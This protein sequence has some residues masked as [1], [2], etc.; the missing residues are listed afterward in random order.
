[1]YVCSVYGEVCMYAGRQVTSEVIGGAY[2]RIR[3]ENNVC[4]IMYVC[5]IWCHF[6]VLLC[7][8]LKEGGRGKYG[9]RTTMTALPTCMMCM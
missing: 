5:I 3:W 1:M 6:Y 9:C 7:F 4:A 8:F 2:M